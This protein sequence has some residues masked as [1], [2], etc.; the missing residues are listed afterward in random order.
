VKRRRLEFF[1]SRDSLTSYEDQTVRS[2][3]VCTRGKG[4]KQ[5][6]GSG[7]EKRVGVARRVSLAN[8][9]EECAEDLN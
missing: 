7:E 5:A 4:N 8:K 2:E 9:H 3:S 1:K 6:A